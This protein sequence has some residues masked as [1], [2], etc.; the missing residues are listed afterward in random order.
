MDELVPER[1]YSH[2]SLGRRGDDVT[3]ANS[4]CS[5]GGSSKRK[6]PPPWRVTCGY[7]QVSSLL[8]ERTT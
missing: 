7:P 8:G 6:D 5:V 2:F 3:T 4:F 1:H